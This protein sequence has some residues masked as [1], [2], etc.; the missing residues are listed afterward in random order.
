[1]IAVGSLLA[2]PVVVHVISLEHIVRSWL[3]SAR[4]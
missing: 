4:V 3:N 1:M 2:L